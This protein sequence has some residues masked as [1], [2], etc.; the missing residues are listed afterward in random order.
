[1]IKK[2]YF[3]LC[4]LISFFQIPVLHAATP[5]GGEMSYRHLSGDKYEIK[6]IIYR[7]CRGSALNTNSITFGVYGGLNGAKS[8]STYSLSFTRSKIEDISP[9][10]STGKKPCSPQNTAASAGIEAHTFLD[11]IDFGNSPYSAFKNSSCCEVTFY[12][13]MCCRSNALTTGGA[14][15]DFYITSTIN[16]CNLS[17]CNTQ[18]NSSA[19]WTLPPLFSFCSN[20]NVQY[21]NGL[22]DT[23]DHDRMV[24]KTVA[25]ISAL[26]STGITYTGAFTAKYPITPYCIP[27]GTLNCTPNP[28]TSPARGFFHDTLSDVAFFTPTNSGE[29]AILSFEC[30]EYRRDKNN[31]WVW[32]GK[33]RREFNATIN[34]NCD[35]S[36]SPIITSPTTNSVCAGDKICFTISSKDETFTPYQTIPDTV[37]STWNGTIKKGTFTVTNPADREKNSEFCWQ[38]TAND[39]SEIPYRFTAIASDQHCD[40]PQFSRLTHLIYVSKRTKGSMSGKL[41]K[42]DDIEF[43]IIPDSTESGAFTHSTI[44][45]NRNNLPIAN[46]SARSGSFTN[47][48]TGIYY[49]TTTLTQAG[50]CATVLQDT[51]I[52]TKSI[53]C[54]I[55]GPS[56]ICK[57]NLGVYN[58]NVSNATGNISYYWT[59]KKNGSI[60]GNNDTLKVINTDLLYLTIVDGQDCKATDSI[61]IKVLDL[62]VISWTSTPLSSICNNSRAII[63]SNNIVTPTTYELSKGTLE[64]W[65][66]SGVN[67][68]FGLI[69]KISKNGYMLN[70]ALINTNAPGG[71]SWNEKIYMSFTDSNGCRSTDSNSIRIYAAPVVTL[72]ISTYCQNINSSINLNQNVIRPKTTFGTT[73]NWEI[74]QAP[75]GVDTAGLLSNSSANEWYFNPGTPGDNRRSGTYIMILAVKDN[76]TGCIGRDT[77]LVILTSTPV[78]TE[79]NPNTFCQHKTAQLDLF[80]QLMVDGKKPSNDKAFFS[81]ASINGNFDSTAWPKN[82]ILSSRYFQLKSAAGMY[83]IKA[84]STETGCESITTISLNIKATPVSSFKLT[85][86]DS[87]EIGNPVFITENTSSISD[88]SALNYNW[89]FGNGNGSAAF[90]PSIQYSSAP[91]NYTIQLIASSLSNCSDTSSK[92]IVVFDKTAGTANLQKE[93]Y[94]I[95]NTFKFNIGDNSDLE[96][97]IFDSNGKLVHHTRS[98]DGI[99]LPPGIY[100]YMASIGKTGEAPVILKGKHIIQ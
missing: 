21:S 19:E 57:N 73:W 91:A 53:S 66:D 41:A 11:T 90:A 54:S 63:V 50:K 25:P 8:C 67:S 77:T 74:L 1:M 18:T 61:K 45:K 78:L 15:S 48:D 23:F 5:L 17:N 64:M 89:D 93:T 36:K 37:L 94:K 87:V 85:P 6:T 33:V 71:Q 3:L 60:I 40:I 42:C 22:A 32:I 82:I 30:T 9:I 52:V 55:S 59:N 75:S 4:L 38:T 58:A 7:D 29:M 72:Q 68:S 65:G 10:C 2:Y 99:E 43:T 76:V 27:A 95:D 49:L 86:T 83:Q 12:A 24:I 69:E 79:N 97:W 80:N 81:I 96:L 47:L 39:A 16:L 28:K 98:N 31:N 56:S 44:L 84:R 88:N 13:Q 46:S 51:V 62:P 35:Y 100:N 14:G 92:G 70:P 34:G 20:Q 26:P